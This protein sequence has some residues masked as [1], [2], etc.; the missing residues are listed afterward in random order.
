MN[1][2]YLD[3]AST[4]LDWSSCCC[5]IAIAVTAQPARLLPAVDALGSGSSTA[6]LTPPA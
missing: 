5:M 2:P 6:G 3:S 4:R 1:R